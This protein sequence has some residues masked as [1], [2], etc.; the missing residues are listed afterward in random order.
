M[1]FKEMG[2][3]RH[4]NSYSTQTP[5]KSTLFYG[6]YLCNSSTLDIGVLGYIGIVWPKEHS[7]EIWSVPPVTP[8]ICI[9]K[10]L[11][12]IGW[13]FKI[14]FYPTF[15]HLNVITFPRFWF[16]NIGF[17]N[18]VPILG[19]SGAKPPIPYMPSWSLQYF[20]YYLLEFPFLKH[21]CILCLF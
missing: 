17:L 16:L 2:E 11:F 1:Q 18:L 4:G 19:M 14:L 3:W 15:C 7:P 10:L 12:F 8:C 13:L 20:T 9:N 6:Q 21:L 5:K